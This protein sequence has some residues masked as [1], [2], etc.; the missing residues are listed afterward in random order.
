MYIKATG[1]VTESDMVRR[2]VAD[3]LDPSKA[4]LADIMTPNPHSV[5]LDTHPREALTQM[6]K[7]GYR[8]LP[9]RS[10]QG[11]LV[12]ILDVLTVMRTA[13]NLTMDAAPVDHPTPPAAAADVQIVSP[14]ARQ[15]Q[16]ETPSAALPFK[17]EEPQPPQEN[18]VPVLNEDE[19][20]AATCLVAGNFKG[21]LEALDRAVA[22]TGSG[23]NAPRLLTRRGA[24]RS[25]IGDTT[26][27]LSDFDAVLNSTQVLEPS[28]LDE[29]RVGACEV[30]TELGRYE[31][32]IQL[33]LG[34]IDDAKRA[35]CLEALSAERDAQRETGKELFNS[36]NHSDA[37]NCFT[38]ALRIHQALT[39]NKG[40]DYARVLAVCY[41][42]RAACYMQQ[43][44]LSMAIDDCRL[45]AE[46][47]GAYDKAWMRWCNALVT[48]GDAQEASKVAQLGMTQL[49]E[50]DAMEK[51][52]RFVIVEQV[53]LEPVA[54]AVEST[55]AAPAP[56]L[57]KIKGLG[58]LFAQGLDIS[59]NRDE[60]ASINQ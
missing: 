47:D 30:Q 1:I 49:P 5:G 34:I 44:F 2:C 14:V 60:N 39:H 10:P 7:K 15:A 22:A 28:L 52:R 31:M 56:A 8:H 37:I 57:A 51:L 21:A 19:T 3:E 48:H 16:V 40:A 24:V 45:S 43:G 17:V 54:T 27:A 4:T 20:I 12:M 33:C 35:K 23:L 13:H 38:S 55:P 36:G 11:E 18:T 32:A 59:A 25:V 9:V 42:N 50:G 26:G 58:L 53:P 46:A 41:A 29:A 6:L